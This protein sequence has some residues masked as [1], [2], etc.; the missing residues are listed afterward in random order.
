MMDKYLLMLVN[1]KTKKDFINLTN[2]IRTLVNEEPKS[3]ESFKHYGLPTIKDI[4]GN[5]VEFYLVGK[6]I[7]NEDKLKLENY[8]G[9]KNA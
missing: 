6:W 2:T 3:E 5:H 7:G 4:A 1:A 8:F 9:G